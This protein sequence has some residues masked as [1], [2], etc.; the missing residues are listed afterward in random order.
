MNLKLEEQQQ[1]ER[2]RN[3]DDKEDSKLS[4]TSREG[5]PRDYEAMLI[6]LEGEVRTHIR[7]EQQL[8]LHIENTQ[9][10]VEDLERAKQTS[11]A[12]TNEVMDGMKKDN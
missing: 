1:N 11:E 5:P 9:Q 2:D 3:E 7:I 6:K 8:K 12:E 10:K 4:E